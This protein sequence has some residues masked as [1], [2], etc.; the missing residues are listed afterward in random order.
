MTN[1]LW[2]CNYC[3]NTDGT[4]A[5]SVKARGGY[6]IPSYC[7]RCNNAYAHQISWR[8]YQSL[9]EQGCA[10]CGSEKRLCIDHDHSCCAGKYSCGRCVRGLLCT[11]CNTFVGR[12]DGATYKKALIYLERT[13]RRGK[14]IATATTTR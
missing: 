5:I 9:T 8:R 14:R 13:I 2:Q 10:I 4:Q 7:K 11:P 3:E 12:L 6:L 1:D